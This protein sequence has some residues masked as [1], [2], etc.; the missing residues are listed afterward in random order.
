MANDVRKNEIDGLIVD[1]NSKAPL[2]DNK[3]T[4]KD[5]LN[6]FIQLS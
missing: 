6:A 4:K 3:E 1:T 5:A 2:N